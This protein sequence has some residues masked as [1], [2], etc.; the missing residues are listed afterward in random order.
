LRRA[1]KGAGRPSR[2]PA[3]L[4]VVLLLSAA[5]AV[6]GIAVL[7]RAR[8]ERRLAAEAA[9][10]AEPSQA[11]GFDA[12]PRAEENRDAALEKV[13][14]AAEP[15]DAPVAALDAAAH[16]LLVRERFEEAEPLVLRALATSPQDAEAS[17]HRA[18]LRGVLDDVTGARAELERLAGGRAGWEASLF[19]AGFA[20]RDGDEVGALRAFRRFRTTAPPGEV[21]PELLAEMAQLEARLGTNLGKK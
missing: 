10:S 4:L 7:A 2:L 8:T 13:L 20:L 16:A 5:S 9:A 1:A 14:A 18:V 6:L 17:I 15:I 21:T 12:E 19:A 3:W 11:L